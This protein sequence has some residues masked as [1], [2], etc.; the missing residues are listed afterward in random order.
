V[1]TVGGSGP[2][3]RCISR[4]SKHPVW[5]TL[6]ASHS[7]G[8]EGRSNHSWRYKISIQH[9]LCNEL[10]S[11]YNLSVVSVMEFASRSFASNSLSARLRPKEYKKIP[12]STLN[13]TLKDIHDLIQYAVVQAQ[14]IIFGQDLD[15]SF[16]VSCDSLSGYRSI[17][18]YINLGL[19]TQQAFLGFTALYWLTIFL[20]P[21][22]LAVIGLNLIFAAPLVFSPQGR[23]VAHDAS[24]HAQELANS[25]AEKSKVLAQNGKAKAAELSSKA[26][27]TAAD[28]SSK[29]KQTA[30]D[31]SSRANQIAAD[32]SSKGKETATDLSSRA[33]QTAT[34]LSSKGRQT[35]ADLSAQARST[36]SD[37][38]GTASDMSGTAT[39][40]IKK[41]PQ[42][43][44]NA[45]NE[46]SGNMNSAFGDA[47]GYLSTHSSNINGNFDR[48]QS[49]TGGAASKVSNLLNSA[50]ESAKQMAPGSNTGKQPNSDNSQRAEM[51]LPGQ[52]GGNKTGSVA[53]TGFTYAANGDTAVIRGIQDQQRGAAPLA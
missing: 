33:N 52:T 23:E 10:I 12:E 40:N 37:M 22:W 24:V 9:N 6:P 1:H 5:G 50:G 15:K 21:F 13:A 8:P 48:N 35:T 26:N 7:S 4:C 42:M 16:A 51:S 3:S 27:Q 32:L 46:A 45:V 11:N 43:G 29:G 20:S 38:T 34:D 49:G 19:T 41:L 30:T 2:H 36:A 14:R 53:D 39:E 18:A 47:K 28:L 44:T 31:L 17:A 25:A